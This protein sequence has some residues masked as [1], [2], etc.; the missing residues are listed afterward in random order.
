MI[1]NRK[2]M[3]WKNEKRR[4]KKRREEKRKGREVAFLSSVLE[5]KG[6]RCNT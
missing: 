5:P 4:E 3:S 6:I 2:E 1:K